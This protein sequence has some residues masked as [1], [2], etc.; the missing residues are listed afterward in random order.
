MFMFSKISICFKNPD[1]KY[2]ITKVIYILW[3]F[4]QLINHNREND[5]SDVIVVS[6]SVT[7]SKEK[8]VFK[9][10]TFFL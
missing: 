4:S 10:I 9:L 5:I 1:E 6:V 8:K 3:L 2:K 7:P